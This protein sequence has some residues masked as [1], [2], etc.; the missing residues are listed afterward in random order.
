MIIFS[1]LQVLTCGV[2]RCYIA[3][4]YLVVDITIKLFLTIFAR[5]RKITREYQVYILH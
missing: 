4:I 1:T 2:G 5:T 3:K